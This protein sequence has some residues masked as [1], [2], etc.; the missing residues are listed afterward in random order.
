MFSAHDEKIS[1]ARGGA[2]HNS[3]P[4]SAKRERGVSV[5]ILSA[6]AEAAATGAERITLLLRIGRSYPGRLRGRNIG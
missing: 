4:R 2:P 5:E 1:I 3:A 6:A